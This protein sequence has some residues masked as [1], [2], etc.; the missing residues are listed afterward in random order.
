[1]APDRAKPGHGGAGRHRRHRAGPGSTGRPDTPAADAAAVLRQC[2]GAATPLEPIGAAQAVAGTRRVAARACLAGG[3]RA[4]RCAAPAL[5]AAAGG[6]HAHAVAEPGT[7]LLW[8]REA[9]SLH[10]LDSLGEA[11]QASLDLQHGPLLRGLLVDLAQ[12]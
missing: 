9:A 5:R 4:S 1:P 12:G 7:A 8:H 2:A 6:W 3:G 11:A 10:E